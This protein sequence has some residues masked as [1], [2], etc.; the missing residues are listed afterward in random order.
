MR[1]SPLRGVG[2]ERSAR[3]GR[4]PIELL[5]LA[6]R[7]GGRTERRLVLIIAT[8]PIV[9]AAHFAVLAVYA[10]VTQ[11]QAQQVVYGALAQGSVTIGWLF[12]LLVALW[13]PLNSAR[14]MRGALE[15]DRW[16]PEQ[17]ESLAKVASLKEKHGVEGQVPG[18]VAFG[19]VCASLY[20]ASCLSS[21]TISL[22]LYPRFGPMAP[23]LF[24]IGDL[25]IG[26]AC[27]VL[28]ARRF[29]RTLERLGGV[30]RASGGFLRG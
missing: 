25:Y 26:G 10:E 9:A 24:I 15:L 8:I 3:R 12:F 5:R 7:S 18:D 11:A 23:G 17:R 2:D 29:R 16:S 21:L 20:Y 6:W 22:V 28:G 1:I 4:G 30:T 13:P 19:Y 27:A 14:V